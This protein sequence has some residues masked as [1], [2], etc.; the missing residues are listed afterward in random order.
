MEMT[1]NLKQ[2]AFYNKLKIANYFLCLSTMQYKVKILIF[3]KSTEKRIS[4]K[5]TVIYFH[6]FWAQ[7]I[8]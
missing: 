8:Q 4:F 1:V 6:S 2:C 7:V 5:L 3:T